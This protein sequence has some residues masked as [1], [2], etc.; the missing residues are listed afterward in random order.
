MHPDRVICIYMQ[1]KDYYKILGVSKTASQE[2]IKKAFRKLAVKYHPDKNP[3]DKAAE[4]KF[5]EANEANEVLGDPEKRKKYDR[6]GENWRDYEKTG[7]DGHDFDW[8]RW[9]GQ[10]GRSRGG[11]SGF[12]EGQFSDF[13]E[14]IF[15]GGFSGFSSGRQSRPVRGEDL[16]AEMEITMDDIFHGSSRQ[17]NINGNRVNLK[18][19]PGLRDGQVLRMKGKGQAG[20]NGGAPGDLLITVRHAENPVYKLKGNDLYFDQYLDAFTAML[21]GK[22]TVRTF[23]K[24]IKIDVPAGTDSNKT[25]RL[26]GMGAPNYEDNAQRGDAYVR[27]I[28]SVPKDLSNQEREELE[29]MRKRRNIS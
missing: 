23:D 11:S 16:E 9:S 29:A 6:L 5:K 12:E 4:E 8:S 28:I 25:F 26:K 20:Y 14:S 18:L 3:G 24:N 1:F 17:V 10:S 2:E 15:G 7:G 21:G 13:F 19:K 22:V 27:M